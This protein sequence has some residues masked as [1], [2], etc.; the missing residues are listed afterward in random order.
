MTLGRRNITPSVLAGYVP[1]HVC[2]LSSHRRQIMT[3]ARVQCYV[4]IKPFTNKGTPGTEALVV[5][6]DLEG[7]SKFFTQQDVHLHVPGFLNLVFSSFQELFG[8]DW[9]S[10][11][12]QPSTPAT[13][14]K[15]V[16]LPEPTFAKFMG[17]GGLYIWTAAS[18]DESFD[19]EA[20]MYLINY[21]WHFRDNFDEVVARARDLVPLAH[22]PERIRF[23]VTRGTVYGLRSPDSRTPVDYIGFSINLAARL[24][25]YC[26]ELGFIVSARIGVAEKLANESSWVKKTATKLRGFGPEIVYVDK[27]EFDGLPARAKALFR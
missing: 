11:F 23:G 12:G 6:F 19:D 21:L 22:L 18:E 25:N 24:Q 13:A 3:P 7:F 9:P 16:P 1:L 14:E 4:L 20:K 27:R 10:W 8:T 15:N 17:D 2:V 5:I 26:R